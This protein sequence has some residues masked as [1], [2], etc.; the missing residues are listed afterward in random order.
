VR[1]RKVRRSLAVH[2]VKFPARW[3]DADIAA[4]LNRMGLSTGQAMTWTAVRV[5]AYRRTHD[6][7]G[8]ESAVKDGRCLSM[9]EAAQ[10]LGVCWFP[11]PMDP[12]LT[13]FSEGFPPLFT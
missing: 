2:E 3:S 8:Y 10:K 6:I 7:P 9:L 13:F 1:E 11:P 4:T 5:G 12:C